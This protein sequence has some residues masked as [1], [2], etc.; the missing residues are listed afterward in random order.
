MSLRIHRSRGIYMFSFWTLGNQRTAL[1]LRISIVVDTIR[2]AS[3]IEVSDSDFS[4]ESHWLGST[5]SARL[6]WLEGL[7]ERTERED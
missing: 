2:K 7:G 6:G 3:A 4:E 5:S 1:L